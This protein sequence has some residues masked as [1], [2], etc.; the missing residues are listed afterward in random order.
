M[1]IC[2]AQIASVF[3]EPDTS[4]AKAENAVQIA[5]ESGAD[6]VVFPEQFPTGW[7]PVSTL[8]SEGPDGPI[9]RQWCRIACEYGAWIVGS[10]REEDRSGMRNSAFLVAPDGM[11]K[12]RYAKLHLFSHDGE[13]Q[14]YI[15]GDDLVT[16]SCSG[17]EIG[18]AICYDLRFPELFRRYAE[19]GA[20]CMVVPAAWPCRR[21][22][23]FHLFVR[24]RAVENQFFVAGVCTTGSNPVDQY[25]GGSLVVGPDGEIL[26]KAGEEESL[27]SA[28]IDTDM[29]KRYRRQFPVQKDIRHDLFLNKDTL[30][31]H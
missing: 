17:V 15:A 12:A 29:L 25:C 11:I 18:L 10:H 24:A 28:T 22:N 30:K 5:V 26:C 16:F 13:D 6:L 31:Q 19:K 20:E 3:E 2:C 9:A 7:D 4:L 27:I 21:L 23:H 14:V 1:E 8:F